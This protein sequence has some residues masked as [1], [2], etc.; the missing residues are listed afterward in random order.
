MLTQNP[1]PP[2][3]LCAW[4]TA[5]RCRTVC[6]LT[7]SVF[8]RQAT[9]VAEYRAAAFLRAASFYQYAADRSQYAARLHQRMKADAEWSAIESKVHGTD[10]DYKEVIVICYIATMESDHAGTKASTDAGYLDSATLLASHGY[11]APERVVGTL[12]LNIGLKLPSEELMGQQPSPCQQ[13]DRAYMSNVCTAKAAQRQGVATQLVQA[14]E[15]EA[16]RQ[17]VKFLYV[18]VAQDNTAA[19]KLYSTHCSFQQEQQESEPYARA[20]SRPSRLLLYKQIN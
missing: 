9:N 5:G 1:Q 6:Q 3:S 17:G 4:Y 20:L 11:A 8:V 18:H 16:A 13:L 10:A 12:D 2:S 15:A 7:P 19:V 14:A